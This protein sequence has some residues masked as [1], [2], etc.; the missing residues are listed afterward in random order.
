MTDSGTT[1]QFSNRRQAADSLSES[2]DGCRIAGQTYA[3]VDG[4]RYCDHQAHRRAAEIRKLTY[5]QLADDKSSIQHAADGR[6]ATMRVGSVWVQRLPADG[7]GLESQ[8][9]WPEPDQAQKELSSAM[10][11][12]LDFLEPHEVEL[13]LLRFQHRIPLREIGDAVGCS[14]DTVSRMITD[15]LRRIHASL[16]SHV[17][18]NGETARTYGDARSSLIKLS[19]VGPSTTEKHAASAEAPRSV[20]PRRSSEE[21]R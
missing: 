11:A 2:H 4:D 15:L 9:L 13:L 17:A 8:E 6:T 12:V 18:L 7:G 19:G 16:V 14:K 21:P 3:T 5:E 20:P 1:N 10:D